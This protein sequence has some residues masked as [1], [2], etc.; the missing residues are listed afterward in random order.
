MPVKP[1]PDLHRLEYPWIKGGI[2]SLLSSLFFGFFTSTEQI[3]A[4]SDVAFPETVLYP[5]PVATTLRFLKS[6]YFA[7]SSF[8]LISSVFEFMIA[9]FHFSEKE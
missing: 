8:A 4:S 3:M 9:S 1:Q 2:R 5:I 7:V 6:S